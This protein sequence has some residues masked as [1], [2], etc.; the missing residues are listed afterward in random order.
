MGEEVARFEA[1]FAVYFNVKYAVM[2][3][4][5]S[6]ANL[7]A[8][9]A[10]CFKEKNPLKSGDEV[11]VPS[12]S[13]ATTYFPLSQYGMKLVF[14]DIDKETLNIDALQIERAITAKTKAIMVPSILG[15]PAELVKIKEICKRNNL[16]LIED[17]C[18]SM[19]ATLDDKYVG[20]YGD[21]GAFSCF[22]SHH[23]ST[24]EGGIIV[25]DDDEL[26]QI[27]LS[28]RA[29]GWTR[30]LPKDNLLVTKDDDE[31]YEQWRFILPGYNLRPLEMS[32]AVGVEQ[33][34]KLP[35]LLRVRRANAKHFASLFEQ[36]ESV[37]RQA[38][39]GESSWFGF[40][41]VLKDSASMTRKS[42]LKKFKEEGVDSRP[43][44]SGNFLR[45]PVMKHLDHRIVGEHVNAEYV[46]DNGL[47]V[48]NHG[49]DIRKELDGIKTIIESS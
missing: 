1:D 34:K 7:L 18:E 24:M 5:G 29:H 25:T 19:G 11:I 36:S 35:E 39:L 46:H 28:L 20:T 12:L 23:I 31:F 22:Y 3:N 47:F 40:S 10:M 17:N 32:G 30:Q 16:Y 49:A 48:G 2:V 9:A 8:V 37:F 45:Q 27:L 4:S 6:S 15:N 21:C 33:L 44:I 38:E 14:V 13:W 26:Y 42:I 41:L 43:I